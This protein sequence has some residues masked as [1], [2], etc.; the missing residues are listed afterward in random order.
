MKSRARDLIPPPVITWPEG[1]APPAR[2]E[3]EFDF[4]QMQFGREPH[5][6]VYPPRLSTTN[7]RARRIARWPGVFYAQ[8]IEFPR[9]AK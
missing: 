8:R 9:G 2:G 7:A 6:F 3:F 4:A 5:R 1:W